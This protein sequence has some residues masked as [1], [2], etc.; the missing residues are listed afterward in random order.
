M[1]KGN[2][3]SSASLA[4]LISGGLDSAILLGETLHQGHAVYPLYVRHGLHWENVELRYLR[5]F[6]KAIHT[7][8]LQPLHVLK[9]PVDDLYGA[10]WS[11]TGHAVPDADAPDAAVFLPGRNVLLLA[12][13]MLWCHLHGVPAVALGSLQTN[14]FPDATPEFFTA[15]GK[16]VNQ[17]VGSHVRVERP[18]A[19]LTKTEVMRRGRGLPLQLTFSCIRPAAGKHCGAC[20]K[21]AERRKAFA[22]A[23]MA[24]PAEYDRQGSKTRR[25]APSP[26][27]QTASPAGQAGRGRR[28]GR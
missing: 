24:D 14:P 12:K 13:A 17:A 10:H 6:L 21:C 4:V 1:E 9:L 18:F 11:M 7:P 20:N 15:Y 22:A 8:A 28:A 27:D 26:G 16:L 19:D 23:G 5:R 25:G 2:G 3:P